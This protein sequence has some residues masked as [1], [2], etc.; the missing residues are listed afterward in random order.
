MKITSAHF[1]AG[2][3]IVVA[4]LVSLYFAYRGVSD[5]KKAIDEYSIQQEQIR[6]ELDKQRRV[7][8]KMSK[9]EEL[10]A[11]IWSKTHE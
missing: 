5:T 11:T 7:Q 4:G 9:P 3:L 1:M 2:M 8:L 6:L 10:N